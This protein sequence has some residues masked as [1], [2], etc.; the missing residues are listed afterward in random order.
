[1]TATDLLLDDNLD[2]TISTSGDLKVS[3]SDY[4]SSVLIINT[5]SGNWKLNPVCGVGIVRY[6]GSSGTQQQIKRDIQVQLIADGF[7]I[8]SCV[9]RSD[10]EFNY[11]LERL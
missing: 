2:L 6:K 9:V 10:T 3:A 5:Y 1:M 7:R 4:Q 8:N 11:D